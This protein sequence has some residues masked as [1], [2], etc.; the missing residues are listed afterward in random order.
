MKGC[1]Q[2]RIALVRGSLRARSVQVCARSDGLPHRRIPPRPGTKQ[3]REEDRATG[4]IYMRNRYY[5]PRLE[6]F[7]NED[8]IGISGGLNTYAFVGGD[9][10]NSA[11][12]SG[13]GPGLPFI[14]PCWIIA[15]LTPIEVT[16]TQ[17]PDNWWMEAA[18]SGFDW[19]PPFLG[20]EPLGQGPGGIDVLGGGSGG[21]TRRG[22]T[23]VRAGSS[24]GTNPAEPPPDQAP[25]PSGSCRNAGIG[26]VM[27]LIGTG[28]SFVGLAASV[29]SIPASVGVSTPVAVAGA[30]T[31]MV[32]LIASFG[33][34]A[35]SMEALAECRGW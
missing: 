16:T 6:R 15:C 25:P 8:P 12:P 30:T 11:D 4:L 9:P 26:V 24:T 35:I 7:L 28:A 10:V 1:G 17:Q 18:S 27:S 20:A 32:G 23:A 33:G 3:G 19:L 2:P 14:H 29:S 13:L 21:G 34:Y 31:S 22:G 5:S